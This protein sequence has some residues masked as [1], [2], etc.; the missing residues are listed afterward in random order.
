MLGMDE[1]RTRVDHSL[2]KD[3][4][5]QKERKA[6]E[7]KEK[8][9]AKRA[10]N[11]VAASVPSQQSSQKKNQLQGMHHRQIS[12]DVFRVT[13]EDNG[14]GMAHHDVPNM[15]GRVLAGTKYCVR[16]ARGKFGLG[17]KMALIWAK[18]STGLPVHITTATPNCPIT[19]CVLD[20]DITNNVP[21]VISHTQSPNPLNWRGTKVTVTIEGNWSTYR[22]KI[23]AYMRQMAVIT[24]YAQFHLNFKSAIHSVDSKDFEAIFSRRTDHMPPPAR[25]VKHHPSSVNQLILKQLIEQVK[26]STTLVRFLSSQ[27]E[28]IPRTLAIRLINELG[29]DFTTHMTVKDLNLN[30]IRQ[31]DALLHEARFEKANGSCLSPAGEYNLRLGIT[32]ELKPNLVATHAEPPDVFEGHPFI[33]EAGVALGGSGM[34]P[35]INIYRFA[36]RIPLLFEAGNDVV[37]KTARDS[38]RWNNYKISPTTDKI[39]VICSIVSTKIPFKGTGKEY[40]GDDSEAIKACVKRAISQCCLQLKTK[41]VR[42]AAQK[43]AAEKKKTI[44]KYAPDVANAIIGVFNELRDPQ[45]STK[46]VVD[47]VQ[48]GEITKDKLVNKLIEHVQQIDKEQAI[49]FASATGRRK[50]QMETVYIAPRSKQGAYLNIWHTA[51]SAKSGGSTTPSPYIRLSLLKSLQATVFD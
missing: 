4:E 47:K 13:V 27:F 35:G 45:Q 16:Q 29:G 30:H 8:R 50:K 1:S 38:I 28:A 25:E 12:T 31:I 20:I 14:C 43:D 42:R 40:I 46:D 6:R 41:L 3:V 49:E 10:L 7:A 19:Q 23:L 33:V 2:Y 37:T 32:K 22:S 21:T 5:N 9:L 11:A 48:N 17:S 44:T 15:M 18:M 26:P 51:D 39:A 24:P 36:N 34:K